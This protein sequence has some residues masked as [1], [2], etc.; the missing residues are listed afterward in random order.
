[1]IHDASSSTWIVEKAK[2][3]TTKWDYT[4]GIDR[5]LDQLDPMNLRS[6]NL[7]SVS[8]TLATNAIVEGR[9]QEVGLL[10]MPPFGWKEVENFKHKPIAIIDGQMAISGEEK[11]PVNPVQVKR[12][13][14]EMIERD[15][16]KAFAVAG[17]AGHV[18]PSHELLVKRILRDETGYPVTCG[19]DVSEGLNYRVRA[20]TAAL[21]ARIIPYLDSLFQK[22]QD[23]LERR[24]INAPV[25]V[26]KSD[27]SL[28]SLQ[29]ARERPIETILSGPAASVAG[30]RILTGCKDAIVIDIGGTTSDTAVIENGI[31]KTRERG[32][33]VGGWETHVNALNM[34]TLGLGGDSL[35]TWREGEIAIGPQR[36]APVSWLIN[37][38]PQGMKAIS[39]VERHLSSGEVSSRGLE[40]VALN[41]D[42][43]N[44]QLDSRERR[45]VD[46]LRR[47]P[48]SVLQL[49]ELTD[50]V[51]WQL[52][53]LKGLEDRHIIQRCGLTPTDLL[54]VLGRID[55]WDIQAAQRMC[56]IFSRLQRMDS[57][58][59]AEMVIGRVSRLVAKELLKKRLDTEVE[60]AD[61]DSSPVAQTLIDYALGNVNNGPGGGPPGLQVEMK[62]SGPVIGIGAPAH[63]FL[64]H[65]AEMLH[66]EAIVPPHADV[67]NAIGAITSSVYVHRKVTISVDEKGIFHLKG[68]PEAP[69]FESLESAQEY[70]IE[71]LHKIVED[72]ARKAGTSEQ[73]VE[74][75]ADDNIGS[76]ADGSGIFLGRTLEARVSGRPDLV[77]LE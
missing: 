16:V 40:F 74:I 2:A 53:P 48:C 76:I 47:G 28:T 4:V 59:F 15:R 72:L 50:S 8:T 23:S 42:D 62:L 51:A 18:N 71:Q 22:V 9:G 24:G 33:V 5:A 41:G 26:V 36:V 65:A 30:A 67:A 60:V 37:H 34:R 38:N 56:D 13:A 7:V 6:L 19:H 61:L 54:H 12:I 64:P 17:Y 70:A 52:L 20:E 14:R 73:S 49:S 45:I 35:I 29:T 11:V 39:W 66:T 58:S 43:E 75:I 69:T 32:A 1:M 31:V 10:I 3:L 77:L 68:L 57:A 44:W 55:L 21:N 25:M 46:V 27:G 63:E